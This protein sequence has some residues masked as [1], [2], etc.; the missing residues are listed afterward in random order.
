MGLFEK[1]WEDPDI[2]HL[3]TDEPRAYYIPFSDKNSA[4]TNVRQGSDFYHD[5]N[6]IW[7]FRYYPSVW[8]VKDGFFL[9]QYSIGELEKIPV[10]SNWQMHGYDKP[11][12]T[13]INYP[14]PCDPPYVPNMNPAGIYIRD[15]DIKKN[16]GKKYYID[17][18]GVD[19][20]FYLW[21]NWKVL[22]DTARSVI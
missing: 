7:S 13:N 19:S 14:Y 8:D 15:I 18:E 3:G 21:I 2:L 5:L 16:E 1:Y 12:Y 11:H 17:F 9:S 6:G 4:L 22:P 10:P 20:C